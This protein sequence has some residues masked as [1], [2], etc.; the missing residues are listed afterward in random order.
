MA[1][2]SGSDEYETIDVIVFPDKYD[3]IKDISKSDIILIEA[4]VEKRMSKYQL[5][6]ANLKKL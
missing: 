3:L 6:L 4:K 5:V 1:F 2:I